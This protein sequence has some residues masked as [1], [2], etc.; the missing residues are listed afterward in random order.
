MQQCSTWMRLFF[1]HARPSA[2]PPIPAAAMEQPQYNLFH[3]KYEET[4]RGVRASVQSVLRHAS[5]AP[6]LTPSVHPAACLPPPARRRVEQ[7]YAPLYAK[8]GLGLTTWSPLAS[9]ILTGALSLS[10]A[11]RSGWV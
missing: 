3:R 8:Y 1:P 7:E 5:S 6:A 4:R 11:Q 10:A 2:L 9:G